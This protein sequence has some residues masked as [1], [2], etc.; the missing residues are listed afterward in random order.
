[1]SQQEI[2]VKNDTGVATPRQPRFSNEQIAASNLE[3]A[4]SLPDLA[5]TKRHFMPL[6]IEYWS[7]QNEGEEKL[8][9][10]AGINE[11]E[12]SDMETGEIKMLE[13]VMLLERQGDSLVRFIC[14]SKVLVG[15]IRDAINRGEI[16]PMSTLTPVAI[17][18]LG[19]KKNKSNAKLSNRWQITPLIVAEQ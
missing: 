1:M 15:N 6:S 18:F 11:H 5:S 14:A 9:F 19:Q 7:P 8:V 16:I 12:V 4:N 3:A 2:A 13:C 10:V 17:R